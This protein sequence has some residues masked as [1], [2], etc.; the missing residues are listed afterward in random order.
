[1]E[2]DTI[3]RNDVASCLRLIRAKKSSAMKRLEALQD[4]LE[5]SGMYRL[6]FERHTSEVECS[7]LAVG[8]GDCSAGQLFSR[9]PQGVQISED[10][11]GNIIGLEEGVGQGL[12]LLCGDGLNLLNQLV[13][14]IEA[15][16]VH[17]LPR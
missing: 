16:K 7:R 6:R 2:L 1:M 15:I 10:R 4:V 12:K 11:D 9:E 17:L 3:A 5:Q 13:E 14:P 8:V